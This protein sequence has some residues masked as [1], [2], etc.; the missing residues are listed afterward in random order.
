MEWFWSNYTTDSKLQTKMVVSPLRT[1]P[2][3]LP[4]TLIRTTEMNV[5]RYEGEAYGPVWT[6]PAQR[7]LLRYASTWIDNRNLIPKQQNRPIQVPPAL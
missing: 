7:S 1:S 4:P 6:P 3:Q 2:D 5:L